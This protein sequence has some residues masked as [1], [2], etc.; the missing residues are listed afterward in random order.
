MGLALGQAMEGGKI[1][2]ELKLMLSLCSTSVIPDSAGITFN[3]RFGSLKGYTISSFMDAVRN[4]F[5]SSA[6]L[7]ARFAPFLQLTSGELCHLLLF[8]FVDKTFTPTQ[9]E[10]IDLKFLLNRNQ[11]EWR[12]RDIYY[13]FGEVFAFVSLIY[14]PDFIPIWDCYHTALRS[15]FADESIH[16]E[17]MW[18]QLHRCIRLLSP[19]SDLGVSIESHI[20]EWAMKVEVESPRS[21]FAATVRE[22]QA[23]FV[24][25]IATQCWLATSTAQGASPNRPLRN[26][27]S[28]NGGN[29][30]LGASQQQSPAQPNKGQK[31][32]PAILFK[33]LDNFCSSVFTG[34][35]CKKHALNACKAFADDTKTIKVALKHQAEFDALPLQRKADLN[36]Y[37]ADNLRPYFDKV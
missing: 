17:V 13:A 4:I 23:L 18:T 27:N 6:I 32:A 11:Q 1:S 8:K 14:S 15:T 20:T 33:P 3:N 34:R 19:L 5:A 21:T 10:G 28:R 31:R 22:S 7:T 24:S 16:P 25:R 2:R 37:F 36:A 9:I 30:V 35:P 26:N 12:L 29:R